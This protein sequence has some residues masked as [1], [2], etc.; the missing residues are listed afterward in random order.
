MKPVLDMLAACAILLAYAAPADAQL[1]IRELPVKWCVMSTILSGDGSTVVGVQDDGLAARWRPDNA[2]EEL[3]PFCP[4][5][6]NRS[7]TRICG[8]NGN[9][10]GCVW[11]GAL[12]IIPPPEG[13]VAF[14]PLS[15]SDNYVSGGIRT[16]ATSHAV[17]WRDGFTLLQGLPVSPNSQARAASAFQVV[18]GFFAPS[19]VG[20]RPEYLGFL[21]Y[22]QTG[23]TYVLQGPGGGAAW[24]WSIS[25]WGNYVAGVTAIP[26]DPHGFTPGTPH[27]A[28]VWDS[29]LNATL[30]QPLPGAQR[31]DARGVSEW[32]QVTVGT[33]FV[34]GSGSR[35]TAWIGANRPI[36]L[37]EYLECMGLGPDLPPIGVAQSV[38]DDGRT[39]LAYT[40]DQRIY[41]ITGFAPAPGP[42]V[43]L[44]GDGNAD[45]IDLGI[46]LS[47]WGPCSLPC[48]ADLNSDGAVD[49]GDLAQLLARWG[50]CAH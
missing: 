38:S 29:N 35:A 28:C 31:S 17:T 16:L 6:V 44:S 20:Q 41:L 49:G 21:H 9:G 10:F 33:C 23:T 18:A 43:D 36:D 42:I 26:G 37:L 34:P 47:A 7:G 48:E 32:G 25:K 22:M 5:G 30:L 8:V 3:G 12:A 15:I 1:S 45:G 2:V 11:D 4:T 19:P 40:P 13:Y 27:Q 24:V 46:L 50:A 39:I 14:D